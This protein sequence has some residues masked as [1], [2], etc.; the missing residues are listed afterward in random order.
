MV[1]LVNLT[2]KF[3]WAMKNGK[4]LDGYLRTVNVTFIGQF[5][6]VHILDI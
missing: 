6:V 2:I 1:E 4:Y 5:L 3:Y